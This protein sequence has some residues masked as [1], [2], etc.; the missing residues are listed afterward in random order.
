M[1]KHTLLHIP[2]VKLLAHTHTHSLPS[3]AVASYILWLGLHSCH[4]WIASCKNL[5]I[6]YIHSPS[7]A[8][9]RHTRGVIVCVI[10]LLCRNSSSSSAIHWICL[11]Q[12][13]QYVNLQRK[14][15]DLDLFPLRFWFC[16]SILV[17]IDSV[18]IPNVMRIL[19][20][21][22]FYWSWTCKDEQSLRHS[23]YERKTAF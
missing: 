23:K 22:C 9:M 13:I 17:L 18:Q 1:N 7:W 5:H 6:Q 10:W 8:A 19:F 21:V 11:V 20:F 4:T 16:L 2:N 3:Y 14:C 15:R 12:R